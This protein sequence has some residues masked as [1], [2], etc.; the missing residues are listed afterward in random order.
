MPKIGSRILDAVS[1][2]AK[3]N[4]ETLQGDLAN[5]SRIPERISKQTADLATEARNVFLETPEGLVGPKY[6]VEDQ[7]DGYEIRNYEGYTVAST[8]MS[9]VGEP[10]SMDE[11]TKGGAEFNALAAYLFGANDEGKIMDMT[12]PVS[13]TSVGE[14]ERSRTRLERTSTAARYA[15]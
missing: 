14:G 7:G 6:T 2:Q 3:R 12:T 13:T 1:N 9:K 4:F 5:P 15:S 10:Y 11:L 8:S